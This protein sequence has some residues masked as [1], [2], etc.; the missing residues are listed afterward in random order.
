[1]KACDRLV[2]I[3]YS[4]ISYLIAR[5]PQVLYQEEENKRK[6]YARVIISRH[7]VATKNTMQRD[8]YKMY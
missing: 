7:I 6:L 1:M 4:L 5:Y 3:Y 8:A 2:V